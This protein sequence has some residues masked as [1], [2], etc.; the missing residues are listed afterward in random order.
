MATELLIFALNK[1]G[2]NVSENRRHSRY[3]LSWY[4]GTFKATG[5]QS[6]QGMVVFSTASITSYLASSD[7][8]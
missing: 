6:G 4:L 3:I 1:K 7:S 8:T 2:T 5:L